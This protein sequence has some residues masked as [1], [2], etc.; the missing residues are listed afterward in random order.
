M[1]SL[2]TL[3]DLLT[4]DLLI[5]LLPSLVT[6]ATL[7]VETV[8]EFVR[9]TEHGMAHLQLVKVRTQFNGYM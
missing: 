4:A 7:S 1:E 2:P 9:M 8:S 6:M 5:P 3:L